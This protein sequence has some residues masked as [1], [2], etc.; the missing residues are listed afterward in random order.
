M[1]LQALIAFVYQFWRGAF[2]APL[3]DELRELA[4]R[5][6]WGDIGEINWG[7]GEGRVAMEEH[8]S[9]KYLASVEGR[10]CTFFHLPLPVV[11]TSY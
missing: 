11:R 3:R 10:S 8:C 5:F 7:S 9:H 1:L 2:L 6:P 4:A